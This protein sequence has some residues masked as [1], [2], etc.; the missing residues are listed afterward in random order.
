MFNFQKFD[1]INLVNENYNNFN[2]SI[3]NFNHS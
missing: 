3:N 1:F 2:S